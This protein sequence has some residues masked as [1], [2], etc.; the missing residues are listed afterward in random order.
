VTT[1]AEGRARAFGGLCLMALGIWI[2]HGFWAPLLWAVILGVTSWPLYAKVSQWEL[3]RR[4]TLLPPV[5]MTLVVGGLLL[6]PA[7]YGL[8]RIGREGQALAQLLIDAQSTG[9]KAPAWLGTLPWIGSWAKQ[10][11]LE[12]LGTPE[13]ARESLRF[14]GTGAFAGYARDLAAQVAHRFL[15]LLI[16][17]LALFFV[18]R[19]GSSVGHR[20]LSL[21]IRLFGTTGS[22]YVMHA[23]GAVRATVNGLVLVGMGEGVLLGA[24]YAVAGLGHPALLGALT[25]L[26]AMIPFAAKLVF[27]GAALV[28]IA[29][30]HVM[31]GSILLIYGIVVMFVADNVVRPYLIGEGAKLPFLWTLLGIFGG[32]ETFGLLGLFLGPTV[33]A[34]LISVWRDWSEESASLP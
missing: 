5:L 26:F 3:C 32:I 22:H 23:V 7:S 12:Y 27:G 15:S 18:Y 28:L 21:S 14:F 29:Q 17:L 8:V 2:L 11:W 1:N 33:M 19:D 9:L 25:G 24:G 13:A 6:I 10:T 30:T 34:V 31:A 4:R 20:I 16:V